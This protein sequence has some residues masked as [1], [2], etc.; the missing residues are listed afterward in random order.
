MGH[1]IHLSA[2]EPWLKPR[3]KRV[4]ANDQNLIIE[5][6]MLSSNYLLSFKIFILEFLTHRDKKIMQTS[7]LGHT[8]RNKNEWLTLHTLIVRKIVFLVIFVETFDLVI[9]IRIFFENFWTLAGKGFIYPL[10]L[11]LYILAMLVFFCHFFM[12]FV[13]HCKRLI[14]C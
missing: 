10:W 7:D 3:N 14:F 5:G 6:I 11:A 9:S 4:L 8:M 2:F 13:Q 1:F 12:S